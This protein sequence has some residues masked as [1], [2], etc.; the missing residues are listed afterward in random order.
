VTQLPLSV[1]VVVA[2]LGRPENLQAL[3][4]RLAT[5]TQLPKRVILSM[6]S[7]SDAP[8]E[9][10]MPFPVERIFGPRGSS[11][12]RN[13]G[14]DLL[15]AETDIVVF[16][17]DDLVPSRFALERMAEF[18]RRHPDVAGAN[19]ILLQ[20]GIKGPGIPPD[21]AIKM[22]DAYDATNPAPEYDILK[23]HAALYGCNMSYRLSMIEEL[24]FD[25]NLPLY[26]WWEDVDF[27][28]RI[29][30]GRLVKTRAFCGV[31][32]GE[33]RGREKNGKLLGYS[34]IVNPWYLIRKG[35]TSPRV[36]LRMMLQNFVSN[37]S[38]MFHPEPWIDRKGRV[39]GNWR[40]LFDI[41]TGRARPDRILEM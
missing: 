24:R 18:Y 30:A 26:A 38:K 35:T 9:T 12:Q 34:Q 8:P 6:E 13:R 1:S 40:G 15:G 27:G 2:S 23:D 32:C 41:I 33:K 20:D 5:Q 25:E 31:H 29:T 22:V 16:Y 17:D 10:E 36:A 7:E 4:E 39:K 19:G 37:H 11:V 21:T 28:G 3:L 14:L